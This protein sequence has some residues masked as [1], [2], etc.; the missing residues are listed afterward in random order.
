V[1]GGAAEVGVKQ[2]YESIALY[3]DV[4]VNVNM[5]STLNTEMGSRE[6][7]AAPK[8]QYGKRRREVITLKLMDWENQ[9]RRDC[10]SSPHIQQQRYSL[11]Q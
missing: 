9:Q 8:K 7:P 10:T 5:S 3:R 4:L 1:Y 2:G 11:L 6:T